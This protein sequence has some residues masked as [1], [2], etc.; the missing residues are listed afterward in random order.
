[1]GRAV[2]IALA[3]A[4]LIAGCSDGG[5]A[6][7]FCEQLPN[8][9]EFSTVFDAIDPANPAGAQA[10]FD[11]AVTALDDLAEVAPSEVHDDVELIA[12]VARDLAGALAAPD[13]AA[14]LAAL[15]DLADEVAQ[16][17]AAS[18][19]IEAYA[20]IACDV[21]LRPTNPTSTPPTTQG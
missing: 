10:S 13:P 11:A 5:D 16:V 4:V 20:A 1:L 3:G 17:R 15:P 12:R 6:G 19:D 7:A 21:N 2:A 8:I 18:E 9:P 14:A